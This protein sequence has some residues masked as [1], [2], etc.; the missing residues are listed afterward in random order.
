MPCVLTD[1][2][3]PGPFISVLRSLGHD[4]VR[5][6]DVLEEGADDRRLLEYARQVGR[7]VVTCDRRF[8]VV[9]GVITDDHGGVVFAEQTTLQ[10]R[11]ED[12]ASGVDRIVTTVTPEAMEG[13]EFYLSAWIEDVP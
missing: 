2:H 6:K 8:T 7:I 13:G 4:V 11:P 3:V 1:E 9:D 12:A 5:S 10:A